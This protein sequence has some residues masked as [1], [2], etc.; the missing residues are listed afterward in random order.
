[1]QDEVEGRQNPYLDSRIK[2]SLV[3]SFAFEKTPHHGLSCKLQ[4]AT[5]VLR[6]LAGKF[7]LRES[8]E[9]FSPFSPNNVDFSI[10]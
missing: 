1:L 9:H 5:K 8:W 2:I 7:D 3:I 10:S 4:W 6:H